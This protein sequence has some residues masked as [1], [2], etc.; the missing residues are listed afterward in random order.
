VHGLLEGQAQ[1]LGVEANGIARQVA[2][3]SGSVLSMMLALELT[4][5]IYTNTTS[6]VRDDK[7]IAHRFYGG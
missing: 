2:L 5:S 1:D 4:P 3:K 6:P 7:K